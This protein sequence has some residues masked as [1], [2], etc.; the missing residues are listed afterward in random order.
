MVPPLAAS[1][2]RATLRQAQPARDELERVLARS[3]RQ[4]QA[5]PAAQLAPSCALPALTYKLPNP[6]WQYARS[7]RSPSP[8]EDRFHTREPS[9]GL[10]AKEPLFACRHRPARRPREAPG[11]RS[12]IRLSAVRPSKEARAGALVRLLSEQ[13]RNERQL[14]ELQ[15]LS[16]AEQVARQQ[17][18]MVDI[19]PNQVIYLPESPKP[20]FPGKAWKALFG[21]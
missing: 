15:S 6:V 7:R 2:E 14:R 10:A 11:V 21:G 19:N 5:E 20:G 4:V 13:K 9:C 16:T 1:V 8:G 18:G 12:V 17:M 3:G